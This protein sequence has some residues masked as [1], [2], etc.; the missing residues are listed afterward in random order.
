MLNPDAITQLQGVVE[1]RQNLYR[2]YW[3]SWRFVSDRSRATAR[4]NLVR[5]ALN[6]LERISSLSDRFQTVLEVHLSEIRYFRDYYLGTIAR[7]ISRGTWDAVQG[8]L[9]AN[10]VTIRQSLQG[11]LA[12][13]DNDLE[14]RILEGTA[15]LIDAALQEGNSLRAEFSANMTRHEYLTSKLVDICSQVTTQ[16][17]YSNLCAQVLIGQYTPADQSRIM[18]GRQI[19]GS[20]KRKIYE[21]LKEASAVYARHYA[22]ELCALSEIVAGWCANTIAERQRS[23]RHYVDT[24]L[25]P[26]LLNQELQTTKILKAC[27]ADFAIGLYLYSSPDDVLKTEAQ[28]ASRLSYA[29]A[30]APAEA[31]M[32]SMAALLDNPEQYDGKVVTVKGLVSD[33]DEKKWLVD[34][35]E[36]VRSEFRINEGNAT[37]SA[38]RS[39]KKFH[40]NGLE[41]MALVELTGTF[42]DD[43]QNTRIDIASRDFQHSRNRSWTDRCQWLASRLWDNGT[44]GCACDWTLAAMDPA[45]VPSLSLGEVGCTEEEYKARLAAVKGQ[46]PAARAIYGALVQIDRMVTDRTYDDRSKSIQLRSNCIDRLLTELVQLGEGGSP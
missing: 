9:A 5:L 14:R 25:K 2:D 18:S 45:E 1:L 17:L 29:P 7:Q 20:Y 42:R 19:I 16:L 28:Y 8:T 26:D 31:A 10:A 41:E 40:D 36:A 27:V 35:R 33:L 39:G 3:N 32:P 23:R 24:A 15:L 44:N 46:Y 11:Q 6:E 37:L 22:Y 38:R 4:R 30:T 34:D 12:T 13:T 43:N 21:A